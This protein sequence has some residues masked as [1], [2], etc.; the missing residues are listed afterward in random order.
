MDFWV[1]LALLA[2]AEV[3]FAVRAIHRKENKAAWLRDRV[4]LRATELIVALVARLLPVVG[5][6][7]RFTGLVVV[8]TVLLAWALARYI[9]QS[10]HNARRHG[11]ESRRTVGAAIRGVMLSMLVLA[12][13]SLPT[14][15]FTGYEGM[16]LTG[17]YQVSKAQAI[18][19]DPNRTEPRETDGSH[20][21][22]PIHFWYPDQPGD[23]PFVLFDHGSFGFWESNF[24][25]CEELASHGYVVAAVDHPYYSFFT[26]DTDGRMITVDP[27]FMQDVLT[28]SGADASDPTSASLEDEWMG[29]RDADINLVLDSVEEGAASGQLG[30]SWHTA[31]EADASAVLAALGSTD[32]QKIGLM[33][34]SIGG[35][36]AMDMARQRDDVDAVID[37]DGT[38]LGEERLEDGHYVYNSEP[39]PA[40][41]LVLNNEEHGKAYAEGNSDGS[42]YVNQ[43]VV[44]H[45]VD[46]RT[47]TFPGTAHMDFTDLPLISPF[48]ASMAGKGS[49]DSREFLPQL[50]GI[51][52]QF[53]DY[54]LKG[55][56]DPSS[57]DE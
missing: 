23:Y 51:V 5:N 57:L 44:E 53:Y 6:A 1:L 2:A 46:A 52:M 28:V 27:Q 49:V 7:W 14:L 55:T 13:A 29:M 39:F 24:S 4:A 37:L 26:Q 11:K 42:E 50:N 47:M 54:Y 3:A 30:D 10:R 43:Y 40:P 22:V 21:E 18:L 48:F 19:V 31:G 41:L 12:L 20:R 16:P 33:G 34:H 56:G 9:F 38:M 36:V 32:T 15:L 17:Q 35:A 25:T 8:T 45:A